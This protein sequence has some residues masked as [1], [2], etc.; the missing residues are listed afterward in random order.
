MDFSSACLLSIFRM[1]FF[2]WLYEGFLYYRKIK[3]C[4]SFVLRCIPLFLPSDFVC[5]IFW[6]CSNV[7][8]VVCGQI[9]LSFLSSFC[10][11]CLDYNSFIINLN[12]GW[13]DFLH[14]VFIQ[15]H[16]F[17]FLKCD[18]YCFSNSR[19]SLWTAFSRLLIIAIHALII[20]FP[21]AAP[22]LLH[23]HPS[24]LPV[25]IS[26]KMWKKK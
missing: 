5:W 26:R 15:K 23:F 8:K 20:S 22:S 21:S 3:T 24:L 25:W 18:Y 17:G 7:L 13:E 12:L 14:L 16:V 2:L 1:V 6:C 10:F 9:Y 4:L 19:T 11:L